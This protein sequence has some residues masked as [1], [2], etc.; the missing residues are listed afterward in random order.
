MNHSTR[1]TRPTILLLVAVLVA[2]SGA[3]AKASNWANCRGSVVKTVDATGTK[4]DLV[5]TSPCDDKK[6]CD[7]WDS[8]VGLACRCPDV[9][10]PNC[11]DVA[12]DE[13]AE[14]E[15][16]VVA[17]G[18]CETATGA[19]PMGPGECDWDKITV[20]LEEKTVSYYVGICKAS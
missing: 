4:W 5:C 20:Y 19:C 2:V 7:K 9:L 14:G 15:D 6:G 16:Q 1:F 11:C 13:S 10:Q 18:L 12:L 8:F 17:S 3:A